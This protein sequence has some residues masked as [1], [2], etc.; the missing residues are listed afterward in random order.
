MLVAHPDFA[1]FVD[2]AMTHPSHPQLP[3]IRELRGGMV[4][5]V[6]R[7]WDGSDYDEG[8]IRGQ[9]GRGYFY[10]LRK[11]SLGRHYDGYLLLL[12]AEEDFVESV[13]SL[14]IKGIIFA[15]VVGGCFLP[16]VWIFGGRMSGS[17]KRVTA[18]ARGL[19]TLAAPDDATVTSRITEIHELGS[20][21]AIARRAIW[22]FGHFVPKDIV[23]GIIDGSISTELGGVRQEVT[24]LFT[25]VSN[26]TG[27][28]ETAD[29]NLL[30]R[31]TSRHLTA[32]TEA[33]LAQGGT[34]D[35]FIGDSVMVFWNAPRPQRDHVERACR[36]ALSAKAA[37]D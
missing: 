29:P 9:D 8:R 16:A 12:A 17:L 1:Q 19:R 28:A 23:K 2:Y 36:A 4:A 10:R 34:V 33:F 15:L 37:S 30:M 25:D 6:I 21:M 11:F 26:F 14:Q 7:D 32:L 20:T 3:G 22:S 13:R 27:I 5:A 18:Q 31:Q 35:K 24:I